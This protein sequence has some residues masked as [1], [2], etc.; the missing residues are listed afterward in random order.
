MRKTLALFILFPTV[1]AA[2]GFQSPS[3][4]IH[5][6]LMAADSTYPAAIRCDI[7]DATLSHPTPPADCNLD[8]GHAYSLEPTGRGEQI[9]AGDTVAN[10]GAAVLGYGSSISQFD[11][12]CELDQAG[13]RCHNREGGGFF[14]SRRKQELF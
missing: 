11:I 8:W 3:G 13:L 10:P 5:C 14:L 1:A 12:T 7:L 4:N 2:T 6:L 9:C